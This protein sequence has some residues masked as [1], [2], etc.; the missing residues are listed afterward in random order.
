M[1]NLA[2]SARGDELRAVVHHGA[3]ASPLKRGGFCVKIHRPLPKLLP[4][5]VTHRN[6]LQLPA[7][8]GQRSELA[9]SHGGNRA[10]SADT[11]AFLDQP[12][13]S[14]MLGTMPLSQEI[15]D[16]HQERLPAG[17]AV[18]LMPDERRIRA[19]LTKQ[20]PCIAV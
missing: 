14:L 2:Y 1:G 8:I 6:T 10:L 13:Q 16:R 3:V 4:H 12:N 18:R 17:R 20:D 11:F 9:C 5:V 7:P 15:R 19:W